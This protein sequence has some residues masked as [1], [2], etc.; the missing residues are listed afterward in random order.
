MGL[1]HLHLHPYPCKSPQFSTW[2]LLIRCVF[3]YTGKQMQEKVEHSKDG[4]G[5]AM[6][7]AGLK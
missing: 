5:K 7:K 1:F 3:V 4:V 6:R 2:C